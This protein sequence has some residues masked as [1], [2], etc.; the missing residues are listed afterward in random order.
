M[1]NSRF[2][3]SFILF[4]FVPQGRPEVI[5]TT[6]SLQLAGISTSINA[7]ARY[8]TEEV[9]IAGGCF[10]VANARTRGSFGS[11]GTFRNG[12]S[13]IG[14]EDGIIL[15]TGSVL[16]ASGPNTATNFT[17]NFNNT[18]TDPDLARIIDNS[19]IPIRDVAILEF[20]FTPTADEVQ[21]EY[22]FASEEYCDFVN[23]DYNDIFGFFI[24]GPGIN[25]PFSNNAENIARVPGSDDFVAINNIN[26]LTN[27]NYYRDNI[28]ATDDQ[29]DNCPGA[30]PNVDGV[31]LQ[32]C[33]Y[34]GFTKILRARTDVIPCATYHIKLVIGDIT[35]G[36]YDSAVFLAAN[37]F[38]AGESITVEG[39]SESLG[40]GVVAE[41]CSDGYFLF[42]RYGSDLNRSL[43]VNYS[44][45]P[46]STA[47]EGID[48][49][50]LPRSISFPAN[51]AEVRLPI[52]AIADG[53]PEGT[54][55][56]VL[57]LSSACSCSSTLSRLN[58]RDADPLTVRMEPL[59]LCEDEEGTLIPEVSGGLAPYSFAWSTGEDDTQLPVDPPA[60]RTYGLTVTDACGQRV[61]Q[62]TEVARLNAAVMS[63]TGEAYICNGDIQGGLEV[64]YSEGGS[65][66]LRYSING[67]TQPAV[68]ID[69]SPFELPISIP[70]TYRLESVRR[71]NCEGSV[72][73]TATVDLLRLDA[74]AEITGLNCPE[75]SDAQIEVIIEEGQGPFRYRINQQAFQNDPQFKNLPPALYQVEVE[76]AR[77]CSWNEQ[78]RIES[79]S[80]PEVS[81]AFEVE[82]CDGAQTGSVTIQV[83]S[84]GGIYQ[85]SLDGTSFQSAPSFSGLTL[86]T[87]YTLWI[88]DQKGCLQ[89][90]PFDIP[91]PEEL[92]V[93]AIE[94][95]PSCPVTVD[96]QII[97]LATGGLPPYRFQLENGPMQTSNTF[98]DLAAGTY[99]V[100]VRDANECETTVQTHLEEPAAL[101]LESIAVVEPSCPGSEDGGAQ[102]V[103]VGGT[104]NRTYRWS[105]GSTSATLAGVRAGDYTLTI[106]DSRGCTLIQQLSIPGEPWPGSLIQGSSSFCVGSRVR[107]GGPVGDFD[108]SWSTGS[109]EAEIW[110]EET[111][112]YGLTVT[113]AD[114]C[115]IADELSVHLS[116]TLSPKIIG[117]TSFCE[118]DSI[119]LT[120]GSYDTYQWSTGATES[121]ISIGNSGWYAVTVS[122]GVACVGVDSFLVEMIAQPEAKILGDE[123]LCEGQNQ[124][125]MV[126][127]EMSAYHWSTGASIREIWVTGPGLY[128]VTFTDD[129]GCENEDLLGVA[130]ASPSIRRLSRSI[131]AGDSLFWN[132]QL[133]SNTGEYQH[134]FS[135]LSTNGCDS[136]EILQLQ[137]H[138]ASTS[139]SM[140]SISEWD[141]FL[142][143][144]EVL[145]TS[146]FYQD[147]LPNANQLG[148]DSIVQLQLAVL[149]IQK[150]TFIHQ[151]CA[152]DSLWVFDEWLTDAGVVQD[153]FQ[154]G[155]G[156]DS[157]LITTLIELNPVYHEIIPLSLCEGEA[158]EE[159]VYSADTS[160]F[161]SY[162]TVEGC[163]SV[164]Q[165][166]LSVFPVYN[167]VDSVTICRGDSLYFAGS[168]QTMDGLYVEEWTSTDAC[169][170]TIGLYLTVDPCPFTWTRT[171]NPVQ[172]AGE[173]NGSITV[174]IEEGVGPF[175]LMLMDEEGQLLRQVSDLREASHDFIDLAAGKYHLRLRDTH[176][177]YQEEAEVAMVAPPVLTLETL[178]ET[179]LSCFAG[180]DG[181][182]EVRGVG[183]QGPYSY[184]WNN[185]ASTP[186]IQKLSAGSYSLTLTDHNGCME[187]V[188]YFLTEPLPIEGQGT[189]VPSWCEDESGLLY[190]D[191]PRG[192]TPPYLFAGEEDHFTMDSIQ[193][194]KLLPN[195]AFIQDANGC[196]VEIPIVAEPIS[197]P[198]IKTPETQIH[199]GD[200]IRIDLISP[201]PYVSLAWTP[202]ESLS[203]DTCLSALAFPTQSTLYR[204]V[205][206]DAL[207]CE[208][209]EVV[210]IRVDTRG[211]IYTPTAFSPNGD[212]QND[213]FTIYGGPEVERINQLSI[214]DRWGSQLF[215]TEEIPPNDLSFGWDGM[216]RGKPANTGT[217]V[218]LADL[219]LSNGRIKRIKGELLLMR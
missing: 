77:G 195:M 92:R 207:G 190:F 82:G 52:N 27:T 106:T 149:P 142:W 31:A 109:T 88:N 146:G 68:R 152:G 112:T 133:L 95:D 45:S 134:T 46:T 62:L 4:W 200:T 113:N 121:T 192:G 206:T 139:Y 163:D 16:N 26:H 101:L 178:S 66:E 21:F 99:W 212:G 158:W 210:W 174:T 215:H 204:A 120:V 13:S 130:A 157:L 127:E 81:L 73:G 151:L 83:E 15:S 63:L 90:L 185:G 48:F 71:G 2:I 12:N 137:V 162:T 59:F 172:C 22:V 64:R 8:L 18:A 11:I 84:S 41:G 50:N 102:L 123:I 97:M 150:D 144:G 32:D 114:G 166:D 217:Y 202:A 53:L 35:D 164:L 9:F 19:L 191:A 40:V 171:V 67:V 167:L 124:R 218:Y 30:Y 182:L 216:I 93:Q 69:R 199:L 159:V 34:D 138:T 100:T 173:A 213:R 29:L 3:W 126:S 38:E 154:N 89:T 201:T 87:P 39:E 47:R 122:N 181:E 170:S 96:G 145:S 24:S 119:E 188:S 132:G 10:D 131:C 105:N 37:S 43:R 58:I 79:I 60:S 208:I 214:F 129:F 136:I 168:W 161:F 28:A 55:S 193:A 54:E 70:G 20:D 160:L 197:Y 140:V 57:E 125:L 94:Q 65:W 110:V 180:A 203:C 198:E 156:L 103:V 196:E 209:E 111:G 176:T 148:C 7:D 128:S 85:Y 33:E 108:Y 155:Q 143:Q 211:R 91:I 75:A 72:S 169:D 147:T 189:F 184:Q 42:R 44:L 61:E 117:P 107:L 98:R 1:I 183:G 175:V 186:L 104:G 153:T 23:S 165:Y 219:Q 51:A 56:I 194:L 116:T 86:Q 177:Q 78:V 49:Q 115:T 205:L 141:V 76:D 17:T 118:G 187:I 135:G 6:K 5:S 74:R 179:P 36:Q 80:M 14:L 25:G